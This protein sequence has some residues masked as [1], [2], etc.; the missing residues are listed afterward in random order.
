MFGAQ[1]THFETPLAFP[2]ERFHS[3]LGA[4]W[5]F[6]LS[7]AEDMGFPLHDGILVGREAGRVDDLEQ[8][9]FGVTVPS[10]G[11]ME[12]TG[13]VGSSTVGLVDSICGA[14]VGFNPFLRHPFPG[15]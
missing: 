8:R 12:P 1:G 4:R 9:P 5:H 6:V 14:G 13:L 10:E 11:P 15:R 2:E 7:D 3:A